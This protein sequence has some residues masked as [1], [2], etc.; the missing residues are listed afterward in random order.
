MNSFGFKMFN[1]MNWIILK[2][3][4]VREHIFEGESIE[5]DCHYEQ[6]CIPNKLHKKTNKL[7]RSLKLKNKKTKQLN[8]KQ[9]NKKTTKQQLTKK[10]RKFNKKS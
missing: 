10:T 6:D 5:R 7:M 4:T 9:E 2:P 3:T 1:P 8:K